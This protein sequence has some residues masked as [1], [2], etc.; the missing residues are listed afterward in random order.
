M[1]K[2]LLQYL[3]DIEYAIAAVFVLVAIVA[4][5]F[6]GELLPETDET[7]FLNPIFER[8][9]FLDIN[10]ISL[11]VIFAIRD[12]EFSDDRLWVVNVGETAPIP[13]GKLAMLLYRLKE[14]GARV[15]GIDVIFDQL[16]FERF[17]DERKD[18]IEA[19]RQ[20]FL[21][22]PN[23]VIVNGYDENTLRS[24]LHIDPVVTEGVKH[25]GYAN[26]I[27]DRDEVV[28]RFYPYRTIEGERWL[29]FAAQVTEVYDSSLVE[30]L[31]KL[32]E[33]PQ[34]IY[35]TGTYLQFQT[36]PI[37]DVIHSD[38]YR[39]YLRDA[40]VLVGFTN[41][42]GYYFVGDTHKTPMGKKTEHTL[43]DGTVVVG[44]EGPDMPGIL[45]HANMVNMLLTGSFIQPVPEWMD[46]IIAFV[47]AYISIA[48]YC[49]LRARAV[50][51]RGVG[52][53]ISTMIFIES[54]I[55][56]FIPIIT[57]FYYDV[58]ISSH[59]ISAVVLLF[60]PIN[61]LTAKVRMKLLQMR[62]HTL[63]LPKEQPVI[64][65]LHAAFEDDESFPS[66]IRLQYA[67]LICVH[68][69]FAVEFARRRRSDPALVLD[70]P[71]PTFSDWR[72]T[73]PTLSRLIDTRPDLA[74]F[75]KFLSGRKHEFL[76]DGYVKN[77]FFSTELDEFNEF[78]HREEWEIILPYVLSMVR[79]FR[80]YFE[81]EPVILDANGNGKSAPFSIDRD[82]T[83]YAVLLP[84]LESEESLHL[85]PLCIQGTCK[86]HRE[87]EWFLFAGMAPKQ[88]ALPPY[89]KYFGHTVSCEPVLDRETI[90]EVFRLTN[91]YYD[92]HTEVI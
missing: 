25:F 72:K 36:V 73:I 70:N 35:Y 48:L 34:I 47:L 1:K 88:E 63:S 33:E 17:P 49:V 77:Q 91:L 11:D 54:I 26:L 37:D 92:F 30:P 21:D 59:L 53:L 31:L 38:G 83:C 5:G 55:V 32:E 10:D 62:V 65:A 19:L 46:F 28:R 3:F 84:K 44:M 74:Y 24:S 51:G 57:F 52:L 64:R 8:I 42:G 39:E 71:V 20:A 61:A 29:S 69:V 56:F 15:V 76:N 9:D 78:H 23:V 12:T 4:L 66:N 58:K 14:Y 43:M 82:H 89:P 79:D 68:Y 80:R 16:H 27:K 2:S 81:T 7:S 22:V 13:D 50:S 40:I 75:Y 90:Q 60:I 6:I 45:V 87:R 85:S 18:E 41:E 67:A 86:L